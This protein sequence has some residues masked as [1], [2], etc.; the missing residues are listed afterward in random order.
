VVNVA[1]DA[2]VVRGAVHDGGVNNDSLYPLDP[3]I[4]GRSNT[5]KRPIWVT[6]GV[7]RAV[8]LAAGMV[9]QPGGSTPQLFLHRYDVK[10]AYTL[11]DRPEV[12]PEHLQAGHRSLVKARLQMP[13]TY[14]L[15][16]DTTELGWT[17]LH[18]VEDLAIGNLQSNQ[19]RGFRLHTTLAVRRLF[20][21]DNDKPS[22]GRPAVEML[23]IADQ[24]YVLKKPRPQGEKPGD[25]RASQ[26]R[27]D[28]LSMVWLRSGVTTYN[29]CSR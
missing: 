19:C 26:K 20:D 24:E 18:S 17:R 6:G 14:L 13:G 22:A 8:A 5:L 15:L 12:T 1:F 7:Q 4:R 10:A 23:G 3:A 11:L 2:T 27:A 28:R 16:E 25:V 21:A 9:R 29:W